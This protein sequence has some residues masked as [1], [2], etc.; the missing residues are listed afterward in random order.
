MKMRCL[1]L[2]TQN[3]PATHRSCVSG[4]VRPESLIEE[5]ERKIDEPLTLFKFL[6][7]LG[8]EVEQNM[9]HGVLEKEYGSDVFHSK[10]IYKG[11]FVS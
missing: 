1:D 10:W 4:V 7:K 8:S 3:S 5:F 2:A 11:M 9:E 6:K